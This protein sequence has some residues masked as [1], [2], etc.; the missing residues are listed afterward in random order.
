MAAKSR[1]LVAVALAACGCGA[2]LVPRR[3]DVHDFHAVHNQR[4][5]LEQAYRDDDPQTAWRGRPLKDLFA[6][7]GLPDESLLDQGGNGRLVYRVV[8]PYPAEPDVEPPKHGWFVVVQDAL[9]VEVVK[10]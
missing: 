3:L 6:V 5:R 1:L 2:P 10:F 8:N 7:W 4:L 9:I